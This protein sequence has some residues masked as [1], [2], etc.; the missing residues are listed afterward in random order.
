MFSRILLNQQSPKKCRKQ[1]M[2]SLE[3][4]TIVQTSS[5]DEFAKEKNSGQEVVLPNA[6]VLRT[7]S[8]SSSN[9]VELK[10]R[11]ALRRTIGSDSSS[12]EADDS[13]TPT[14]ELSTD[15][16]ES[17]FERERDESPPVEQS[18]KKY[19]PIRS[20][21]PIQPRSDSVDT[22]SLILPVK[23]S[24][25]RSFQLPS[26]AR[27]HPKSWKPI[28][29]HPPNHVFRSRNSLSRSAVTTLAT[30]DIY[31]YVPSF[32]N[33][34]V[35]NATKQQLRYW[36]ENER[37]SAFCILCGPPGSGKVELVRPMN[38]SEPCSRVSRGRTIYYSASPTS[39]MGCT[40]PVQILRC[41]CR[42]L[43]IGSE[44]P[45][46]TLTKSPLLWIRL[47]PQ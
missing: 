16:T 38:C 24:R 34:V 5:D 20:A 30:P 42:S 10:V 36:V 17:L 27:S 47:H 35:R 2:S 15:S 33:V 41:K 43:L 14:T 13:P 28:S 23:K 3:Q 46:C 31:A 19:A 32:D 18:A 9:S 39:W 21:L 26:Q 8:H 7:K 6:R 22:D 11:S 45:I 4:S 1:E 44:A 12:S 25:K 37:Q 40:I 29:P